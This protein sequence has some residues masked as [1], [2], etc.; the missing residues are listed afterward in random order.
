MRTLV[1]AALSLTLLSAHAQQESDVAVAEKAAK[2]AA[3]EAATAEQKA[4]DAKAAL[5]KLKS[6]AAVAQA[7]TDAAVKAD[8]AA[9][10]KKADEAKQAADAAETV[11]KVKEKAAGVDT[12]KFWE[13]WGVGLAVSTKLGR[14]GDAIEEAQLVNGVIRVSS[15]RDVVPRLMLERHWYFKTEWTD[16]NPHFRQ[17]IFVGASLLGDKKLMDAV[18]LGWL[19]AFRPN[20]GDKVTHNLGIGLSVEPYSRVLGDGLEANKPLPTGETAIRYKE[21]NRMAVVVFYTFTPN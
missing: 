9:A 11:A 4:R 1:L 5:D 15:E 20:T 18:S 13:N 8:A 19:V 17:G 16:K 6:D 3:D 21:K 10:R 14:R 7:K 2:V 12:E